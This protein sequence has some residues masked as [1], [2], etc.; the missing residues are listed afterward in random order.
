MIQLYPKG[1]RI[2]FGV[3]D[4]KFNGSVRFH[5]GFESF[6]MK[7]LQI[8][9]VKKI[10]DYTSPSGEVYHLNRNSLENWL[11][12][13]NSGI[14]KE[15][16]HS[17][18]NKN[19]NTILGEVLNTLSNKA[20][21]KKKQ[22]EIQE[23]QGEIQGIL[24]RILQ[25]Q[26]QPILKAVVE[27]KVKEEGLDYPQLPSPHGISNLEW[28]K[29]VSNHDKAF[30][31]YMD[32]LSSFSNQ[33][34]FPYS[35]DLN[36]ENYLKKVEEWLKQEEIKKALGEMDHFRFQLPE[37]IDQNIT[38]EPGHIEKILVP[39]LEKMPNLKVLS[40]EAQLTEFPEFLLD[41]NFPH[42]KH[43]YLEHNKISNISDKIIDKVN[44]SNI[45]E[46]TLIDNPLT[47]ETKNKL[48]SPKEKAISAIPLMYGVMKYF[49][50]I[51]ASPVPVQPHS[52]QMKIDPNLTIEEIMKD[53]EFTNFLAE[54]SELSMNDRSMRIQL[55]NSQKSLSFDLATSILTDRALEELFPLL[56]GMK[57]LTSINL[58]NGY[59]TQLPSFLMKMPSLKK[60]GLRA[61]I[62]QNISEKVLAA[63]PR[64]KIE[65]EVSENP[66]KP[67][68]QLI[69]N[70][71]KDPNK[72]HG[73]YFMRVSGQTKEIPEDLKPQMGPRTDK[74]R[75]GF[76]LI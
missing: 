1:N 58:E 57:N 44:N 32:K 23:K 76:E 22:G 16:L 26:L 47:T 67:E 25:D 49:A 20:T 71:P 51:Q 33:Y 17:F 53:S 39:I 18:G 59:L 43:I 65:V 34:R 42:L 2:S 15:D 28:M 8:V 24:P 72:T 45:E 10:F 66:L 54:I 7:L 14:S 3:N 35:R 69:L 29:V 62:I 48:S 31:D 27:K 6:F 21:E 12:N 46:I 64:D 55:T 52:M 19:I 11:A 36:L 41:V 13:N 68:T 38:F 30:A 50:S 60:V 70:S 74:I 56:Q 61:N 5:N 73:I 75:I 63:F 37:N 9:G 4:R 40:V